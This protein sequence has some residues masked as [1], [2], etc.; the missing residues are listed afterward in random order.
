M[1]PGF[2]VRAEYKGLSGE[3]YVNLGVSIVYL[4]RAFADSKE[5]SFRHRAYFDCT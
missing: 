3:T 1:P 2:F 5:L 4:S